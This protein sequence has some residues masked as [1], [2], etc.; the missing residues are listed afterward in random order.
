LVAHDSFADFSDQDSGQSALEDSGSDGEESIRGKGED[1]MKEEREPSI[2]G[3]HLP[4]PNSQ[5]NGPRANETLQH[6]EPP[7]TVA[8]PIRKPDLDY[9]MIQAQSNAL[10]RHETLESESDD[11]WT[12]M[13]TPEASTVSI[14]E[15]EAG[16]EGGE[17]FS[18]FS[19]EEWDLF[20][21]SEHMRR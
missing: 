11:T 17:T 14:L 21:E 1:G 7:C 6:G 13:Q 15:S 9:E 8:L 20:E 18:E 3:F 5:F 2:S 19:E 16:H 10:R 4:A 12:E